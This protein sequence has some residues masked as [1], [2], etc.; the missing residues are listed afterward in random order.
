MEANLA[1]VKPIE[2]NNRKG[3]T[4]EHKRHA[5]KTALQSDTDN[6]KWKTMSKRVKRNKYHVNSFV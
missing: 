5:S 2:G 6:S 1:F 3:K 4:A